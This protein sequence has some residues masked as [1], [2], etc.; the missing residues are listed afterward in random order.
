MATR[1]RETVL[2]ITVCH[3]ETIGLM[4]FAREV[5]ASATCMSPG[6]TGFGSGRP[7]PSPNL[8]HFSVLVPKS[9]FPNLFAVDLNAPAQIAPESFPL[10]TS[11]YLSRRSLNPSLPLPHHLRK[12]WSK[13][14]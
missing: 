12:K 10:L 4:L 5:P 9:L 6:I 8:R 11:N 2:R 3:Q 14:A 13:C 1:T 7:S